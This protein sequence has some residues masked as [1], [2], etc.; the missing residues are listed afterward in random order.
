M[1]KLF[2]LIIF[3]FF[4]GCAPTTAPAKVPTASSSSGK[5]NSFQVS[6]GSSMATN[7][8][9]I[10]EFDISTPENQKFEANLVVR[11]SKV[12]DPMILGLADKFAEVSKIKMIGWKD[13]TLTGQIEMKDGRVLSGTT[14][15]I[16]QLFTPPETTYEFELFIRPSGTGLATAIEKRTITIK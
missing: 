10:V 16:P 14:A 9:V 11:T 15:T 13:N 1:Q 12:K 4:L 3:I 7:A 8:T 5:I 2:G 6:I